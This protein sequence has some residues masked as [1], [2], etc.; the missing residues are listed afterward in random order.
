M[1]RGWVCW[2]AVVALASVLSGEALAAG[3]SCQVSYVW[4]NFSNAV[5]GDAGTVCSSLNSSN[6]TFS[7][8]YT[9]GAGTASLPAS[10]GSSSGTCDAQIQYTPG[11]CPGSG[12]SATQV[13]ASNIFGTPTQAGS[14]CQPNQCATKAGLE[15]FVGGSSPVSSNVCDGSCEVQTR[16]RKSVV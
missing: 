9:P 16:D 5:T 10:G 12:C 7:K 2:F 1:A 13:G 6:A 14:S 4:A 11:N 3:G 15:A 8:T